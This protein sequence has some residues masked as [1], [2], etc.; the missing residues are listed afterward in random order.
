MP[1]S[2]ARSHPWLSVHYSPA[3]Y[4]PIE[5]RRLTSSPSAESLSTDA[6][7]LSTVQTD[8]TGYQSV[9]Y[10]DDADVRRFERLQ[11]GHEPS[12]LA[13]SFGV[14]PHVPGAFSNSQT[15]GQ[16]VNREGSRAAPLQRRS[17]VLSQAAEEDGAEL[18]QPSDAMVSN[19]TSK[20]ANNNV[21]GPSNG[22]ARG[23][24]RGRSELTPLSEESDPGPLV[25]NNSPRKKGKSDDDDMPITPPPARKVSRGKAKAAP[26]ST[27]TSVRTRAAAAAAS[28]E[29]QKVR[30]ST[31]Q[32]QKA[33]RRA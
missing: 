28:G 31:R 7:L 27:D 20:N 8:D 24:K 21:A 13:S 18:P 29:D 9:G 3:D 10:V 30:R 23:Y 17:H 33:A 19:A 6:S 26:V 16:A 32:P 25:A 11:L 14:V 2:S 4:A 12:S 22:G 1:L 15:N 5:F